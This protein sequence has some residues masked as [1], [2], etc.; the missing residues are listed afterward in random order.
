MEEQ[1]EQLHEGRYRIPA[2]LVAYINRPNGELIL[3][4]RVDRSIQECDL[5]C[6]DCVNRGKGHL[7]GYD[8]EKRDVCLVRPKKKIV[9]GHQCYYGAPY[10]KKAC[11]LF[12][13]KDKSDN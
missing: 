9:N 13:L 10:N 4:K 12:K 2:D 11:E 3:K 6:K 5:R 7:W 1:L 8:F